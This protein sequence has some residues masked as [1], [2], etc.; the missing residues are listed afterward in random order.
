M[1]AQ[2]QDHGQEA[3][4]IELDAPV[5]LGE[6]AFE[7]GFQVLVDEVALAVPFVAEAGNELV[8]KD[9]VGAPHGVGVGFPQALYD[10]DGVVTN[11]AEKQAAVC[12]P[13]EQGRFGIVRVAPGHGPL[14]SMCLSQGAPRGLKHC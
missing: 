1:F 3:V 9:Q 13:G 5:R 7:A 6:F 11:Q 10:R 2:R 4:V 14:P 12:F 8:K